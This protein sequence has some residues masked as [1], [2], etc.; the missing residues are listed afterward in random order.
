MRNRFL[1]KNLF[2]AAACVTLL[3]ACYPWKKHV[4]KME[5]V[6]KKN[7]EIKPKSVVDMGV[8]V[9]DGR[10]KQH[11]AGKMIGGKVK[12]KNF[13]IKVAGGNFVKGKVKI[14]SNFNNIK[15]HKVEVVCIFRKV[16]ELT[17][18]N[19]ILLNYKGNTTLY[20]NGKNGEDGKDRGAR[21]T[22]I[23]IGGTGISSGKEGKAGGNG[24]P[25]K[26]LEIFVR[27]IIDTSYLRIVGHDLYQVMVK[28]DNPEQDF[29]SYFAVDSSTLSIICKGGNG[30]IGGDGGVG[31]DGRDEGNLASA[32]R[33]TDGGNGGNGGNGGAGGILKIHLSPD[34]VA[35]KNSLIL[36][37]NGGQGGAGGAGGLGGR[38]GRRA[39]G[40]YEPNGQ[41]GAAGQ[42]G[43]GNNPGPEPEFIYGNFI[44]PEIEE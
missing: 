13:D 18:T 7:N 2:A 25:G 11:K 41:A 10:G 38:G 9:T 23:K 36:V 21:I 14:D 27:K 33:G 29:M 37:N 19:N 43:S 22:P 15:N 17:D 3:S 16:P 30:G 39:D 20:Y 40:K 8:I 6:Y 26:T 1:F 5:V 35:F 24:E 12:W 42:W 31:V 34:A 44:W 32:G 4:Y 28:T